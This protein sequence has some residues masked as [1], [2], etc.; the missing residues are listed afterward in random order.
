VL[1]GGYLLYPLACCAIIPSLGAR[2]GC[3]KEEEGRSVPSTNA[4][5]LALSLAFIWLA[6]I[7]TKPM[8]VAD[9]RVVN[10]LSGGVDLL[11]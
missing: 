10:P 1:S 2:L 8:L 3:F 9:Q 4:W 11:S 7:F 6:I 5:I